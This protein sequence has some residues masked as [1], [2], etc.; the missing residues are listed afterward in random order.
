MCLD[1]DA[2]ENRNITKTLR[3]KV[4]EKLKNAKVMLLIA[5]SCFQNDVISGTWIIINFF[6]NVKKEQTLF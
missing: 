1:L 6:F 2:E 3:G 4:R 5:L